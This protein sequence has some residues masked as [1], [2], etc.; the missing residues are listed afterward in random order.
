MFINLRVVQMWI[1]WEE[2]MVQTLDYWWEHGEFFVRWKRFKLILTWIG[3][4]RP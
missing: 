1:D 4:S 3:C 2:P